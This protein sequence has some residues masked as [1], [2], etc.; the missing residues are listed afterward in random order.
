M[1]QKKNTIPSNTKQK[2]MWY[3]LEGSK[4]LKQQSI[5][6]FALQ[7]KQQLNE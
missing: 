7:T 6:H 1:T 3:I 4:Y 2:T 5:T